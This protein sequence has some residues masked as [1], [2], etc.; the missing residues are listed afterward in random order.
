MKKIASILGFGSLTAV[1]AAYVLSVI[2]HLMSIGTP[3]DAMK[4]NVG[5]GIVSLISWIAG[6]GVAVVLVIFCAFE[7]IKLIP[8]FQGKEVEDKSLIHAN[9]VA[10]FAHGLYIVNFLLSLLLFAIL[11]VNVN[12]GAQGI[13]CLI[14]AIVGLLAGLG[15][16]FMKDKLGTLIVLICTLVAVFLEIVLNFMAMGSGLALVASIFLVIG[17]FGLVAYV[18]AANLDGFKK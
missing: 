10:I 12:I 11:K 13:F 2:I 9:T 17:L 15:S 5:A 16:A 1:S 18:V 3:F 8:V 4:N 14:F 7:I 6:I